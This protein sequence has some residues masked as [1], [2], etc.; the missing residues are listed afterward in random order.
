M[1]NK[2]R[3]RAACEGHYLGIKA[4]WICRWT[5]PIYS[6]LKW[7]IHS[8]GPSYAEWQLCA[9]ER[10][11]EQMTHLLGLLLSSTQGFLRKMYLSEWK[12][13]GVWQLDTAKSMNGTYTISGEGQL[14]AGGD[15]L[16]QGSLAAGQCS[17]TRGLGSCQTCLWQKTGYEER[18]EEFKAESKSSC[19]S[20]SAKMWEVLRRKMR[21][22]KI[23][24]ETGWR[25][26]QGPW[27]GA[28]RNLSLGQAHRQAW[29]F[30]R[31]ACWKQKWR[32][33]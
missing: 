24:R 21:N 10:H 1:T 11:S 27:K 29:P 4:V 30:P 15:D 2:S 33:E 32:Q 23:K 19:Q 17:T 16:E 3:P 5:N 9:W 28:W 26:W 13:L 18:G 8:C 7:W 22:F 25:E 20:L 14:P 31:V 6:P 12:W